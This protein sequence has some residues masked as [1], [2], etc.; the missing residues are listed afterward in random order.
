MGHAE[1][2]IK[3]QILRPCASKPVLREEIITSGEIDWISKT[4]W[5]ND[6]LPICLLSKAHEGNLQ[7]SPILYIPSFQDFQKLNRPYLCLFF[8]ILFHVQTLKNSFI[9]L[10]LHISASIFKSLCLKL[11]QTKVVRYSSW[12]SESHIVTRV[13][14]H[15]TLMYRY[16]KFSVTKYFF[17]FLYT[18]TY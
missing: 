13:P 10:Q 9:L 3:S 17:V 2:G 4:S 8:I 1:L 15:S 16:S 6:I 18:C 7:D 12:P 14:R 11:L 5:A